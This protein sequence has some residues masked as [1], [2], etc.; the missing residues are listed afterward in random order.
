M[1]F[2]S[3]FVRKPLEERR[4]DAE[5]IRKKYA[6]RIPV[7]V[8]RASSSDPKLDTHKFLVPKDISFGNFQYI[9]RDRIKL[10]QEQAVFFFVN[11]SI[12]AAASTMAQED[13]KYAKAMGQ[14][15]DGFFYVTYGLENVFG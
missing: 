2:H 8:D 14:D 12:P 9:V 4:A 3:E 6:G 10:E 13:E 11:N 1:E 15:H 5:T 7:V